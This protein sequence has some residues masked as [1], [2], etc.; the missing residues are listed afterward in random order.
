MPF[1]V[2]LVAKNRVKVGRF[3]LLVSRGVGMAEGVDALA[4]LGCGW[5]LG[6][7]SG[8]HDGFG[9]R[10]WVIRCRGRGLGLGCG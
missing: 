3:F 6:C 5:R 7:G 10:G 2:A 8:G 4:G 1:S 9:G